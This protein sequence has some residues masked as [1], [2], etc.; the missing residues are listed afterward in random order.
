MNKKIS[1]GIT[2]TLVAIASAI[3]FILTSSI[4]LKMYNAE[5][6]DVKERA[7]AYTKL[8]QIDTFVRDNYFGEVDND[9]VV[10][11]ISEG[12]MKVLGD[13]YA[14]YLSA[15]ASQK[16][17]N[18]EDGIVVGI[19]VSV[20]N[21]E[22]GYILIS[23]VKP[24]SPASE[25]SLKVG[26]LIVAI[27]S[28]TVIPLGFDESI[29]KLYGDE[30]TSV[31]LTIRSEG[32]DREVVMTRRQI[33]VASVSSKMIGD[34]GYIKISEFN[35]K[36]S[37]QFSKEIKSVTDAG[38]KGLVFDLRNNGGGLLKPTLA[39]LDKLL[40]KGDIATATYKDG[41]IEVLGTS[42]EK[43]I[44]LPMNVLVNSQTASAAEL[45]ASALRDYNKAT[46]VGVNTFGKGIMQK[47]YELLDG[48]SISF[49]VATYKTTV[50]PNFDGV[51]LKPNYEVTM[52]DDS[53]ATLATLD[54]VSDAQLQKAIEV[55]KSSVK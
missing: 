51:G 31:S 44:L 32:V 15:E 10:N 47:T 2:I 13:K 42:D 21:D 55:L 5:V 24:N 20:A 18:E 4:S 52:P 12:Y 35:T 49:T 36:T 16:Q 23:E 1:L 27:N 17:K 28:E 39:I 22:S 3:T 11:A 41:R 43:E 50:A 38:A 7:E 45:F 54:E 6:K 40:P 33:E 30:G 46:L 34:L 48:S 37:E 14:R 53:L 25:S 9:E 8:D 29:L 19:G 26:E